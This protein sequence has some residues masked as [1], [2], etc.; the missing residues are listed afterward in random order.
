MLHKRPEEAIAQ[1][2]RTREYAPLVPTFYSDLGWY[3][4]ILGRYDEALAEAKKGVELGPDDANSLYVLSLVHLKMGQFDEAVAVARRVLEVDPQWRWPLAQALVAAGR[5]A[6]A[7]PL[8]D[9]MKKHGDSG[10][11][12]GLGHVYAMKGDKDEAFRWLEVARQKRA[13]WAPFMGVFAESEPLRGDPR[14]TQYLTAI[15]VPDVEP[16]FG[17]LKPKK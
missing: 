3:Y 9:A 14:M 4:Q 12:L 15:G 16:G 7:Q 13:I 6:E 17:Q 2:K 1:I 8:I 5:D 11:A 10:Q